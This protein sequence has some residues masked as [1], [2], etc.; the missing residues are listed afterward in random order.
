MSHA[1]TD[2]VAEDLAHARHD[3]AEY[4]S[5][6]DLMLASSD[7]RDRV[8]IAAAVQMLEEHRADPLQ[9]CYAFAE[10]VVQLVEERLA[11]REARPAPPVMPPAAAEIR[12]AEDFPDN[13][14]LGGRQ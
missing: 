6:T 12:L 2:K 4:A 14:P 1:I 13:Q 11:A 3:V 8:V 9:I 5:D 10:A 7:D